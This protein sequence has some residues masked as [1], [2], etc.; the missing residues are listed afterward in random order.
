M[1]C[2]S[3]PFFYQKNLSPS[4]EDVTS[5]SPP[6]EDATSFSSSRKG[7]TS[8]SP[9]D[10]D[11]IGLSSSHEDIIPWSPSYEDLTSS[12]IQTDIDGL[13]L[14][15]QTDADE[16]L[17]QGFNKIQEQLYSYQKEGVEWMWNLYLKSEGGRLPRG[18]I[19]ADDMG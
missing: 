2:M 4:Y 5:S 14:Q 11:V 13:E 8:Q 9:S 6:N 17:G 15:N 19:L 18:G 7:L 12:S 3:F 1:S 10:E 16:Q